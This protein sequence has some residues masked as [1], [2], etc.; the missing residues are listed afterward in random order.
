MKGEI[1]NFKNKHKETEQQPKQNN[2]TVE[3][4]DKCKNWT[5]QK[6]QEAPPTETVNWHTD[7]VQ[8]KPFWNVPSKKNAD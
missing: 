6:A 4:Y 3:R 7:W 5:S 2:Q 1:Y 8:Q